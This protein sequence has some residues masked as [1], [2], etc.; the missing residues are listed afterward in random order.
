MP[1]AM[2]AELGGELVAVH[3]QSDQL[4]LL[5]P[6]EQRAAL[7]RFAGAAEHEK[8]LATSAR[9]TTGW[10]AV[11]DDL[12][13]RRRHAGSG[14]RR[15]TC[16]G[17]AST[18]SPGSTRSPARTRSCAPRPQ[19]L[20]HAEGLRAAAAQAAQAG[21]RRRR[22]RPTTPPRRGAAARRGP[23]APWRRGGA[24]PGAGRAG[25]PA[26][27]GGHPGRR[28]GGRAGAYAD[29]LDADPARLAVDLRAAGRAARR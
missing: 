7:D 19:R 12:A 6:A 29:G 8:L 21:A 20:E 15:P 16:C 23:G 24:G 26:G 28:R 9:R 13:D 1:V 27:G 18:R 2:L 14:P 22:R 3:G 5:R 10:R 4:R 17:S 25:A 11:V